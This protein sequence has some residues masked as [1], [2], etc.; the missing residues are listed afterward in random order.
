M[1]SQEMMEKN[2]NSFDKWYKELIENEG[3]VDTFENRSY[4]FRAFS[5]GIL[6]S[7]DHVDKMLTSLLSNY[8]KA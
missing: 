8:K 4:L 3:M 7:C 1:T 6:C 5:Y 2:K